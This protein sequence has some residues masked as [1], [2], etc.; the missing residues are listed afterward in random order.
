MSTVTLS[1]ESI[2][3]QHAED[4]DRVR[5]ERGLPLAIAAANRLIDRTEGEV[6]PDGVYYPRRE[7]DSGEPWAP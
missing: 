2:L 7:K 4:L 1:N 6:G 5:Q 3:I